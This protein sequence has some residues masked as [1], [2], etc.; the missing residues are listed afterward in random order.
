MP[1]TIPMHVTQENDLGIS[2]KEVGIASILEQTSS[3]GENSDE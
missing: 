3:K 2:S 1:A